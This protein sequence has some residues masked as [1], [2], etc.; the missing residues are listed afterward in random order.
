MSLSERKI[1][2]PLAMLF[3]SGG[4]RLGTQHIPPINQSLGQIAAVSFVR[5]GG[6]TSRGKNAHTQPQLNCGHSI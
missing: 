4:G 6:K 3:A 5:A 1:L 2:S